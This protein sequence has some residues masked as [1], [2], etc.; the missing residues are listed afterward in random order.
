MITLY[1]D[2][3]DKTGFFYPSCRVAVYVGVSSSW[4]LGLSPVYDVAYPGHTQLYTFVEIDHDIISTVIL[5]LP[6]IQEGILSITSE[7]MCTK[8]CLTA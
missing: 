3:E 5:F 2:E 4:C 8:Y 6:L 1:L 7:R